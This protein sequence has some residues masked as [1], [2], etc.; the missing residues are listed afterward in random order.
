MN[1]LLSIGLL[2]L[3]AWATR[4]PF[5]FP[6]L[7]PTAFL[8]YY[9]PL[10]ASS[11]PRNTIAGHLIGILAGYGSLAA[12]S[13]LHAAP[14]ISE[15]ITAARIGAAA[16]SLAACSGAMVWLHVPHPPAGATTLI[17]SLGILSRPSELI[18]I[19]V[20]VVLMAIQALVI[21]RLAGVRY[22]VW[23]PGT[24]EVGTQDSE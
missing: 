11:S 2:S 4:S 17:V 13:L 22:P 8:V 21:N 6:S 3:L 15:G 20:A 23:S 14:A 7:G 12:F 16:L 19:E 24:E 10:S 18:I 1:G 5:I 9:Q